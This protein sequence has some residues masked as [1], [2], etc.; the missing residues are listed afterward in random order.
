MV[1][2]GHR[3]CPVTKLPL[4][5]CSPL[6]PNYALRSLIDS[7]T[8]SVTAATSTVRK[9]NK[10]SLPPSEDPR[11]LFSSLSYPASA[12]ALSTL[13]RLVKDEPAFRRLLADSGA[14]S[15][16]LRHASSTDSPDLQDISLRTLL[17]LS[18]DGDDVRVGLVADGAL[19]YL[20]CA[21]TSGGPNAALAATTL[22]SLAVVEVNKCTIGAH[23]S[24]ITALCALLMSGKERECREA[25]TALFEICKFPGN[26]RRAVR[27]GAVHAPYSQAMAPRGLYRFSVCFAKCKEGRDTMVSVDGFVRVLAGILRE[28]TTRGMEHALLVLN[29]VC[30]ENVNLCWEAKK[31]GVREICF[32]LVEKDHEKIARNALALARTLEKRGGGSFGPNGLIAKDA[33]DADDL[34]AMAD[35]GKLEVAFNDEYYS[36]Y[37]HVE[38]LAHEISRVSRQLK[39]LKSSCGRYLESGTETLS[40]EIL[41]KMGA[42]PKSDVPIISANELA[43]ADGF[44]FGF[45]TRFGMMAAQFKAFL[46]STGGLWRTQQLAG[47]PAGIFYSTGSQGGGQETTP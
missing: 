37:G 43:E 22:T 33:A 16:L 9:T 32:V 27:A 20:S 31:E 25:T 24:A 5:P 29:L 46:D 1:D 41:G 4:S 17:Y 26:R 12:A 34:N 11:F 19:D 42:P 15:I 28:G 23:P 18:L 21:I 14:A 47:K 45:P 35:F 10:T 40:E 2:S 44:L 30:S 39:V 38:K 36:T 7:F 8:P 13:H 6:I 3:T